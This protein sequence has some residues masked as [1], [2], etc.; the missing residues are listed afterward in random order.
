[1]TPYGAHMIWLRVRD[2]VLDVFDRLEGVPTGQS[3]R[4]PPPPP[5]RE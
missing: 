1:M 5:E 2:Q 3:Q 4:R